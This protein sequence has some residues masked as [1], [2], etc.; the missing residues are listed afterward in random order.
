M[1][2]SNPW[3][4]D[5]VRRAYYIYNQVDGIYVYEDGSTVDSAGRVV[6]PGSRYVPTSLQKK[7]THSKVLVLPAEDRLSLTSDNILLARAS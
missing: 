2:G 5:P 4:W 1:S 3:T 7:Q 6:L